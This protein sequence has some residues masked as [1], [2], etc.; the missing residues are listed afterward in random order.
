[1]LGG[2]RM[3]VVVAA[4]FACVCAGPAAASQQV[5]SGA[6]GRQSALEAGV[7]SEV[8]LV[9]A[10]RGLPRL[11][12]SPALSAAAAAH[13]R[14]MGERGFF[15]HESADGSPFW[16]RVQRFYPQGDF[17]RWAVGENLL[18]ASPTIS[19]EESLQR[20]LASPLHRKNL[21]HRGWREFGVSAISVPGALGVYESLD[22]TIM[23]MDFGARE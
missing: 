3:L 23:T 2:A 8:N 22:V 7:L 20:W 17:R 6:V 9:R 11:R 14:T 4:L 21:L 15:R 1:M 5:S 18:W 13:T 12:L 16:R 19:A 10:R